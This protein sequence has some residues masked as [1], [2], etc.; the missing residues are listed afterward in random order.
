MLHK[1]LYLIKI[2]SSSLL[3]NPNT[4]KV[5]KR[6]ASKKYCKVTK[7]RRG[8]SL[9]RY[10]LCWRYSIV[11]LITHTHTNTLL[12]ASQGNEPGDLQ[13]GSTDPDTSRSNTW[14]KCRVMACERKR[15]AARGKS[16]DTC[17]PLTTVELTT[18]SHLTF[19]KDHWCPT[20][21]WINTLF[22]KVPTWL[23]IIKRPGSG[24]FLTIFVRH[25]S[26]L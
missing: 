24:F 12:E 26:N 14:R 21:I 10:L 1:N 2:I 8:S 20:R 19:Y 15:G 7:N 18:D 9:D 17:L 5:F 22:R 16:I 3:L 25:Y 6:S 11:P 13:W 23:A 4:V